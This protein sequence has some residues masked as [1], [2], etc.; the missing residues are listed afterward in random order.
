MTTDLIVQAKTP[1]EK[2]AMQAYTLATDISKLGELVSEANKIII[3]DV[4][5]IDLITNARKLRLQFKSI[6]T[7]IEKRRKE[8]KENIMLKGRAIDG[9][10]NIIKAGIVPAEK[11]L[12]EQENYIERQEEKRLSALASKRESEIAPFLIDTS[13]YD[14]KAMSDE[15][16]DQLLKSSK[17]AFEAQQEAERKAE[18]ERR[19]REEKEKAKQERIRKENEKLKAEQIKRNKE[20][21]QR[22]AKEQQ[23]LKEE[24]A[25]REKAETEARLLK[26]EKE[27]KERKEREKKEA[28]E[29]A[30]KE[31]IEKMKLAPDKEKLQAL[32]IK[33]L[34][35]EIPTVESNKAKVI[36]KDVSKMLAEVIRHIQTNIDNI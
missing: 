13:F 2:D 24:S 12:E 10:A 19:K 28:K 1:E 27:E 25:A 16:F 22:R 32:A 33:I 4:S 8:L 17:I 3:N 31:A 36:I 18:E 29:I 5:Q 7:T 35:T 6:R 21:K 9:M 23:R 34:R 11:H 14:L 30:E 15:G 20:E 26:E